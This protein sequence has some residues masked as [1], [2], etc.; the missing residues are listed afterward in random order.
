MPTARGW[1]VVAAA[2]LV[3]AALTTGCLYDFLSITAPVR[4]DVLIVESWLSD[5]ALRDAAAEFERGGYKYLMTC[6]PREL[7]EVWRSSSRYK[8]GPEL[9]A[10]ALTSMGL[11]TEL[12]VP[13]APSN[14]LRD[15]TYSAALT[16]AAWLGSTNMGVRAVNVYSSGPHAR[17]SRLLYQKA[18]GKEVRVG[19]FAHLP[20]SYDPKDWWTTS[21]GFQDV[22]DEAVAYLYARAF[23]HPPSPCGKTRRVFVEPAFSRLVGEL[24]Q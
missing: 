20:T 15:R 9:A 7:A 6:G 5:K 18:L 16:A 3:A 4:A 19:V 22:I 14:V 17:R 24:R 10:A 8:T 11:R 1:L 13:L 12:I 23:F 21:N 2:L